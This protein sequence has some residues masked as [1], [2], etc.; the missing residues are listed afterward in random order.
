MSSYDKLTE[1]RAEAAAYEAERA[2]VSR[3]RMA[4]LADGNRQAREGSDRCYCGCKYWEGDRCI[5]CGMA[6][7]ELLRDPE[8]KRENREVVR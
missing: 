1:A 7:S 2:N 3:S 5:D 6:I 8:W 4:G